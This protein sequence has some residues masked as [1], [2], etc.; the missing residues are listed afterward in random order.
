MHRTKG[1]PLNPPLA[2]ADGAS[3]RAIS[4]MATRG[5]LAD[6]ATAVPFDG[7]AMAVESTGGVD[8][9]RRVAAG[10]PFD[11]VVLAADAIARLAA[12]GHLEP[13]TIAPVADSP[14]AIA[15]RDGAPPPRVDDAEALRAALL[16]AARIGY[17]TGPSGQALLELLA[18]WQLAEPLRHRLV[19]APPGVPVAR[20]IAE[21]AVDLGFQQ[22]SELLGTPGVAL[23]GP[24][25]PGLEIV[26]RFSGAVG[27]R[28]ARPD[29]ARRLLGWLSSDA[30][31]DVRR[32]HGMS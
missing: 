12:A 6:L 1:R 8:A 19:Q 24:M 20:L 31:A 30:T 32:R 28:A 21:G 5:L 26:T 9:A 3:V 16:G 29:D 22:R 15:A 23:L 17:S 7:L 2:R 13:G 4:S 25:P 27:T 10:E 14:M 18:R 11:L